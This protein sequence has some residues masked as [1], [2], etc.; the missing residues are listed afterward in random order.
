MFGS[1]AVLKIYI[2]EEDSLDLVCDGKVIK[3]LQ[4]VANADKD[5]RPPGWWKANEQRFSLISAVTQRILAIQ[6]SSVASE[7]FFSSSGNLI[8]GER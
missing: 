5:A 2:I 6:A 1:H 4:A 3:F 7:A 8:N